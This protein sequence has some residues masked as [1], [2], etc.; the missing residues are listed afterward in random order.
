MGN[1]VIRTPFFSCHLSQPVYDI[2]KLGSCFFHQGSILENDYQASVRS[3]EQQEWNDCGGSQK[4]CA[5]W[6]FGLWL[7]AKQLLA[8]KK[9]DARRD[10][11]ET[12]QHRP[13]DPAPDARGEGPELAV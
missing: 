11:E 4:L 5:P 8:H 12:Q 13:R 9:G 10:R 7:P 3:I 6:D 1:M 2:S